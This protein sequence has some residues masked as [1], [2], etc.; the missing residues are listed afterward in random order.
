MWL[1]VFG[2][3]T[4]YC[5]YLQYR[6]PSKPSATDVVDWKKSC[7]PPKSASKRPKTVFSAYEK[8]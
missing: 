2:K 3:K 7:A 4:L 8:T 1:R 6:K 5:T